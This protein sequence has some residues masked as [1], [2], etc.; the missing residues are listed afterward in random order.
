MKPLG[1]LSVALDKVLLREG[2]R[3]SRESWILARGSNAAANASLSGNCERTPLGVCLAWA[4]GNGG[5]SLGLVAQLVR[6]RA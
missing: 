3:F 2:R 6:A 1:D 4:P 5:S